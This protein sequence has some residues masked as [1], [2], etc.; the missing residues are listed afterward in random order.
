MDA[1]QAG[2]TARTRENRNMSER[3]E[4]TSAAEK[5]WDEWHASVGFA[6]DDDYTPGMPP[7]WRVAFASGAIWATEANGDE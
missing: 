2:T 4:M 7:L 3:D 5:A 1:K 6:D